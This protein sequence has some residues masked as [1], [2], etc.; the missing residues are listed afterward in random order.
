MHGRDLNISGQL[1]P[2]A[3]P[4][5]TATLCLVALHPLLPDADGDGVSDACDRCGGTTARGSAVS[6]LGCSRD[7]VDPDADRVCSGIFDPAHCAA[8]ED[9]CASVHNA[10]QKNSDGDRVGN[11]GASA[12]SLSASA[13]FV[14]AALQ[15]SQALA[16][17][18]AWRA[19]DRAHVLLRTLWASHLQACDNCPATPNNSQLDGDR[20][21]V[22]DVRAVTSVL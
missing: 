19:R 17:H 8:A 5:D 4:T 6:A 10:D 1:P 11:V 3:C 20:D 18:P 22:G 9:N 7:Q 12:A 14:D 16:L 15:S 2:P 21:G 13:V